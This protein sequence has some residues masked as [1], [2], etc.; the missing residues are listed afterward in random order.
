MVTPGEVLA[1]LD[2]VIR[3]YREDKTGQASWRLD[4]QQLE[5]D[6][7]AMAEVVLMEMRKK[8]E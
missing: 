5:H 1:A 6:R 4:I 8:S 2:L 3:Y 7:D